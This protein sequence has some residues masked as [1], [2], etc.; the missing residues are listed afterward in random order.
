M[1]MKAKK[2]PAYLKDKFDL[3]LRG[4]KPL[5]ARSQNQKEYLRS[6]QSSATV[7][8]GLG[9]AGTGK[10]YLA[11]AYAIDQLVTKKVE[12]VILTRA[13]VPVSGEQ[14]GFLPGTLE[15]KMEPWTAELFSIFNERIGKE[16]TQQL[17]ASG[18]IQI[19]PFA[20]MRG[21]TFKD[22]IV[23]C[24]E[25]QNTTPSQAKM[26]VTRIGDNTRY[27]INGD[28]EQS[29]IN[30]VNGLDELTTLV[31]RFGLPFP[32]TRFTSQDVAR[33]ETCRIWVEAYE[34]K[35]TCLDVP[36]L[37]QPLAG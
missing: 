12:K 8:F 36:F 9:P 26:L 24:D 28:L 32:V 3:S 19:I 14:I 5:S 37:L 21:R 11:A 29:D 31:A 20:F 4:A 33:S 35:D 16:R 7:V 6:L 25:I 23:L 30:G 22:A 17:L 15:K 2:T 1:G 13:T 18:A 27:F 34:K 10:T